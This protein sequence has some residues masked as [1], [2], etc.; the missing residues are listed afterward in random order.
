MDNNSTT[1]STSSATSATFAPASLLDDLIYVD[2]AFRE[3][4]ALMACAFTLVLLAYALA[5]AGNSLLCVVVLLDRRLHRPPYALAC[6]LSLVGVAETT[7]ALPRL[8]YDLSSRTSIAAGEC[9]A[10]MFVYHTLVR[11]HAL[12]LVAMA[13]D[14]YLAVCHPLRYRALAA[15]VAAS[16]RASG[17]AWAAAAA[18]GSAAAIQGAGYVAVVARLRFCRARVVPSSTCD[19]SAVRRL[20][21]GE[22]GY[23]APV[24]YAN[25]LLGTALP[26]GA[27]AASY[28]LILR[29]CRGQRLPGGR[30]RALST[31]VTHLLLV[32]VYFTSIFF[33]FATG[34]RL[35]APTSGEGVTALQTVQ[36]ILPPAL[37]PVIY[38]LRTAEVRRG[39]ARLLPSKIWPSN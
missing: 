1:S 5:A 16:A 6:I 25:I 15:A 21:C 29:E 30:R 2:I 4:R 14:R 20:M 11:A 31:C 37:N 19:F 28:A 36:F 17:A 33:T 23:E 18:G 7:V 12:V 35:G 39:L 22:V 8:L 27:V 24:V 38:G 3:P 34:L 9:L 13:V 10:R 26:L 32:L